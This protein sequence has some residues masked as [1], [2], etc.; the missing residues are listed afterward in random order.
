MTR[1]W[2]DAGAWMAA[3]ERDLAARHQCQLGYQRL[4]PT[5][6]FPPE[7]RRAQRRATVKHR[8][9]EPAGMVNPWPPICAKLDQVLVQVR[10]KRGRGCGRTAALQANK[11]LAALVYELVQQRG[12][13]DALLGL[14]LSRQS[15]HNVWNGYGW[16]APLGTGNVR[17]GAS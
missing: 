17:K 12:V 14:D 2:V 6:P 3:H 10:R 16:P 4:G 11:D 1:Q 8:W 13:T 7:E 5:I 15:L 9:P